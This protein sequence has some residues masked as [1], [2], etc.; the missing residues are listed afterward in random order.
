MLKG[1]ENWIV[2]FIISVQ[3]WSLKMLLEQLDGYKL[4]I[5]A[6]QELR[7]LD[8][9]VMEKRNHVIFY[10]CQ[11]KSH[12][13]GTGFVSKIIKHL[14]LDFQ[15]KSHRTCRPRIKG[16]FFN[17]SLIRAHSPTEDKADEE[18][19]SFCD[20]LDEIYGECPKRDCKIIIGDMNAKVGKEQI[21]RPVIG[22]HS[23][24]KRSN[25][26]GKRLINFASSKNVV[27]VSTMFE[28]KDIHKGHEN[29]LMEMCLFWATV[30]NRFS[31]HYEV[32]L[33]SIHWS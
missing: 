26:N 11:K 27:V 25:D 12:M 31:F 17:Y 18:K 6:I 9:R 1:I 3:S 2:D 14:I 32:T 5:T 4:D 7:W 33:V 15:V 21:Y 10:S 19:D 13:F 24:H 30:T 22:K 28:H 8:K 23:L 16:K 20:D 29:P